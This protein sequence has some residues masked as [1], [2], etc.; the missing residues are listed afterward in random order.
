M[1]QFDLSDGSN[2]EVEIFYT[3]LIMKDDYILLV[4]IGCGN[5]ASV[6]MVYQISTKMYKAMKIQDCECYIDG[7][8][9]VSII[10]K[11]NEFVQANP[12]VQTHC[13]YMLHYF[14][15]GEDQKKQSICTVYDLYAGSI[16]M[17]LSDGKYKYGLPIMVVKQITK[18]LLQSLNFLHTKLEVVHT[19]IKP[20]NILF[21]GTPHSHLTVINIFEKSL[22]SSRY[23]KLKETNRNKKERFDR[24]LIKLVTECVTEL[25]FLDETFE[26]H[27][28]DSDDSDSD[29]YDSD[30]AVDNFDED[31]DASETDKTKSDSESDVH[32]SA[33]A[34]ESDGEERI[35]TRNQSV[36]DY[37]SFA[38]NKQII[39]L[40]Q[41]YNFVSVN[42]NRA[43]SKDK[44]PVIDDAY[45]NN[46]KITLT[47]FGNSYF[48]KK[49][50]EHEVQ[51]R[52]YRAPEV[53]LDFKYGYAVDIWSVG[54]VVFELLTGFPLFNV[55]DS[56]L[57]QDI[58]HLF[59]FEKILGPMPP[60][61]KKKSKRAQFLFDKKKG[62]SIKNIPPVKQTNLVEIL[63]KQY[64]FKESEAKG[65]S[66]FLLQAL[67]YNPTKRISADK[68]LLHKWLSDC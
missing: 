63:T 32:G 15:Y 28:D 58:H 42:N 57:T 3:G 34:S 27:S 18:Q 43:E 4:K 31:T 62:Y 40:E 23:E 56:P 41:F 66:D 20:E 17:L 33:S 37:M 54:C 67:Q 39:D 16:Q 61:M 9:E 8:R 53:I 6:W 7:C 48:H 12:N 2:E 30:N 52:V 25:K 29:D 50:T 44:E 46:C 55:K 24:E 5:N 22:F 19:D 36:P 38:H 14:I 59:L 26:L 45:V 1:S 13:I 49:R 65:I 68:M 64:L 21:R 35:N 47:D 11:I 10:K 51:D 60:V